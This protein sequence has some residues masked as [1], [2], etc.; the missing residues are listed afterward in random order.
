MA[1][2]LAVKLSVEGTAKAAED[3]TRIADKTKQVANTTKAAGESS[4]E[5]ASKAKSLGESLSSLG[6]R[7]NDAKDVLEGIDAAAKGGAGSFFGLA[8]AARAVFALFS[9]GAISVAVGG[10]ALIA[11][12]AISLKDKLGPPKKSAEEL[13]KELEES[14]KWAEQLGKSRIQQLDSDLASAAREAANARAELEKML[15]AAERVDNAKKSAELAQNRGDK[16][17]TEEERIRREYAISAKYAKTDAERQLTRLSGNE[18][19]AKQELSRRQQ[20]NV[21]NEREYKQ[22]IAERDAIDARERQL[23]QLSED[24]ANEYRGKSLYETDRN[25]ITAIEE[26][27]KKLGAGSL[28]IDREKNTARLLA[29]Q[30]AAQKGRDA[31]YDAERDLAVATKDLARERKTQAEEAQFKNQEVK[32]NLQADVGKAQETDKRN[33]ADRASKREQLGTIGKQIDSAQAAGDFTRQDQLREEYRR[34]AEELRKASESTTEQPIK[35]MSAAVT[36]YSGKVAEVQSAQAQ[37]TAAAVAE[38]LALQARITGIQASV[39]AL[40]AQMRANR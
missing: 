26:E 25:K 31:I 35:D 5:A 20:A 32:S 9:G 30:D 37:A 11:T 1:E 23:R 2:N 27:A 34:I 22:A 16:S 29:A 13:A 17:I 39:E 12:A 14:K 3:L 21:V 36:A 28:G 38:L 33:A 10:L 8:K 6:S 18:E 4:G 15:A 40:S 24:L 7:N 19:I